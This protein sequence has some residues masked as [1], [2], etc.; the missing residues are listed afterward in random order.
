MNH[1]ILKP[2]APAIFAAVATFALFVPGHFLSAQTTAGDR[3]STAQDQANFSGVSGDSGF[4]SNGHAVSTPNDADLG[5]QEILGQ[6]PRYQP[7]SISIIAPVFYTSNAALS[8]FDAKGDA[9]FAPAAIFT[10]QP[11]FSATLYGD[12]AAQQ[13]FFYYD[14]FGDL[15]FGSFDTR[16]GL[17]YI[18][19]QWH[20]ISFRAAYDYNRLTVSDSLDEELFADQSIILIADVPFTFADNQ[21]LTLGT[22]ARI[23]VFGDPDLPRRD[24]FDVHAAYTMNVTRALSA[25][26]IGRVVVRD[27]VLTDRVDVSESFTAA[28]AYRLT[29]WASASASATVAG[30]QSNDKEFDYSVANLGGAL[31][32]MIRF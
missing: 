11:R 27:Y 5:E 30:N 7:F 23:S 3:A 13:Q 14:R 24:D 10:Y 22:G 20:N 31:S 17:V 19:P 9:F 16:A 25:S 6:A 15:D 29:D 4:S 32:L 18:V 21:Q 1:S 26:V 8:R 2:L 12:F 28:L